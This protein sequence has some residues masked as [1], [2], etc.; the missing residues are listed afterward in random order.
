MIITRDDSEEIEKLQKQLASE[1]EM[2]NLGGLKY[3]LGIEVARSKQGIFLSQRKYILDLLSK[4]GLLDC[5][6]VD[7]PVVQ[8]HQLGEYPDQVSTDKGTY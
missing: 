1:F 8:N 2:K 5:N 4:V 7:T 3:F 6:L